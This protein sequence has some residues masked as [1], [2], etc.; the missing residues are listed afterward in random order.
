MCLTLLLLQQPVW[1]AGSLDGSRV[2]TSTLVA[3]PADVGRDLYGLPH[4]YESDDF[5]VRWGDEGAVSADAVVE[6]AALLQTALTTERALGFPAP[7]GSEQYKL[8]VYI[9]DSGGPP[10]YGALGYFNLDDEGWPMLVFHRF[11]LDDPEQSSAVTAH[12]LLHVLQYS[13]NPELEDWFWEA[14]AVWVEQEVHP[15]NLNHVRF[16]PGLALLP[17]RALD[18]YDRPGDGTLEELHAYGAFLYPRYLTE[19]GLDPQLIAEVWMQSP[20]G[21]IE[22][23]ADRLEAQG[24]SLSTTFGDF[25]GATA[26]WDYALGAEYAARVQQEQGTWDRKPTVGYVPVGGTAGMVPAPLETL[27]EGLSYNLVSYA[28]PPAGT[29]VVELELASVGSQGS[30]ADWQPRLV[31]EEA[32]GSNT[33]PIEG[34]KITVEL[35]GEERAVWLVAAQA[36]RPDIPGETWSWAWSVRSEAEEEEDV[37]PPPPSCACAGGGGGPA[38]LGLLLL[39]LLRRRYSPAACFSS[40]KPGNSERSGTTTISMRRLDTRPSR[41]LLSATGR[42]SP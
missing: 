20:E 28:N 19:H 34:G 42:Y 26:V 30:P 33:L 16:A 3:P 13:A 1:L 18:L 11:I 23:L 40:S 31:V 4:Q 24:T 32:D 5:V 37:I 9:G 22:G 15:G 39:P 27:P 14:S 17:H 36:A 12:E 6:L 41:V 25:A 7:V 2:D 10:S 21:V 8:N 29:L 35:D 38:Y